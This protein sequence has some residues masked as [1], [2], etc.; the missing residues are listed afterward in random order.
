[1]KN[2]YCE[3]CG[4]KFPPQHSTGY[5]DVDEALA[6]V[7]KCTECLINLIKEVMTEDTSS[8]EKRVCKCGCEKSIEHKHPNAKFY[9][10]RHKDKYWTIKR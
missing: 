3:I 5:K 8:T 4:K 9:N 2:K 1:M 7:T 10:K 6:E